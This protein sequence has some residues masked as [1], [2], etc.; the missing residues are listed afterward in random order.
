MTNT[1]VVNLNPHQQIVISHPFIKLVARRP[2]V[3]EIRVANI[4]LIPLLFTGSTM[5]VSARMQC[6]K[7]KIDAAANEAT[8]AVMRPPRRG[9]AVALR[10]TAFPAAKARSQL[11]AEV[12]GEYAFAFLVRANACRPLRDWRVDIYKH[13][14][15]YYGNMAIS[16]A[17]CFLYAYSRQISDGHCCAVQRGL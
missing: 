17:S 7:P 15:V 2:K 11:I 6:Y 12:A 3:G 16:P 4:H 9:S 1:K 13:I 5:N 14:R 10:Q 8:D